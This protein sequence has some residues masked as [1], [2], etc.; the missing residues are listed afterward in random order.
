MLALASS[1]R[2]VLV[3]S[4]G[5]V[6]YPSLDVRERTAEIVNGGSQ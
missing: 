4:G 6:R 2:V 5:R 3:I 1:P